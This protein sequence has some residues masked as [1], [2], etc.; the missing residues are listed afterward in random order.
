MSGYLGIQAVDTEPYVF[1]SYNTEDQERL[2]K[3]IPTLQNYQVNIWYDNGIQKVSDEEWQEQIALHIR[4]AELAVFFIS[5]GIFAKAKSFVRKE[6]DLA[7]RHK[8]KICIVL[9]DEI[10]GEMIPAKYDFWW[11]DIRNRQCIEAVKMTEKK[12]AE[13]IYAECCREGMGKE[14]RKEYDDIYCYRNSAVLKNKLN[15]IEES[16]L[17]AEIERISS[18]IAEK[19]IE[20][21][22]RGTYNYDYLRMLHKKIYGQI[23][24]WAGHTRVV[25]ISNQL[26]YCSCNYIIPQMTD[27]FEKLKEEKYLQQCCT[28][29][30]K[31]DRLAYYLGELNAIH[32]FRYGNQMVQEVFLSILAK[33][34]GCD[35]HFEET[36]RK[37]MR[38]GY[39]QAYN[40]EYGLLSQ[41]LKRIDFNES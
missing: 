40:G 9:M 8:K 7:L 15:I 35:L 2:R 38:R 20:S 36:D 13:E 26:E 41:S 28:A 34:V 22:L 37:E 12:L 32:P 27:L 19:L 6:Y 31:Y 4:N 18:P 17:Y 11:E 30:Q 3:I 5:Q 16:E 24:E 25:N 14:N 1:V 21:P 10:R 23:F 39:I 29:E 33:K